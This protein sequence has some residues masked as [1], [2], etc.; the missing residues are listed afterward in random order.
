MNTIKAAALKRFQENYEDIMAGEYR[1]ELARD[2]A[3]ESVRLLNACQAVLRQRI[4]PLQEVVKVELMG[5]HVIHK[6]MD[7]FWEAAKVCPSGD[8]LQ[9]DSKSF[10][11]KILRLI[12]KNYQLA[13]ARA[14][15][16]RHLP[17]Q[18]CRLQL[19]TDQ[20]SGM[21]DTFACTLH[22]QLRNS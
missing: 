16:D 19:V 15:K 4:F 14:I 18:Y 8:P 2:P 10:P 17:E 21:T 13:L 9:F 7:A 11:G 1:Y 3:C 5:R 20:V 22:R 6:L 12:S